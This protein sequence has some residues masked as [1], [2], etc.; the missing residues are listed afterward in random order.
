MLPMYM[1][2]IGE[3][4]DGLIIKCPTYCRNKKNNKCEKFYEKI[5]GKE[6]GLYNCPYGFNTYILRHKGNIDLFTGFRVINKYNKK[7]A[8]IKITKNEKNYPIQIDELEEYIQIFKKYSSLYHNHQYLTNFI[9]NTFHDIRKFNTHIKNKSNIIISKTQNQRKK[10]LKNLEDYGRNIWAMS[11]FISVRLDSYSFLHNENPLKVGN[12]LSLNI[13]KTFDKLRMCLKEELEQKRL[14]I[15]LTSNG[16][17]T[18]IKAYDTLELIPY[19]LLDNGIKYSLKNSTIDI[20]IEDNVNYQ[21]VIV[22][23]IGPR[24]Y[25]DE[26]KKIFNR[27]FRGKNAE[28]LMDEGSGIGMYIIK[29]V[30]D[31][32]RVEIEVQSETEIHKVIEDMEYSKFIIKFKIVK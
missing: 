26:I 21:L 10:T 5:F 7:K 8:D 32:H 2:G 3:L 25:E 31:I 20:Y 1:N 18:D 11:S 27:G 16:E 15:N 9:E 24:L 23:S 17:C 28:R 4:T 19:L 13:Y 6:E 22:E 14:K 12:P 30:C 29:S